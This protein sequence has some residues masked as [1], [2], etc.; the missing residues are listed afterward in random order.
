MLID[1]CG[2]DYSTYGD[3]ARDGPRFAVV[4][5]LLSLEHNWR[6]RVRVFAPDDDFPVVA[7]VGR[8]LA[9]RELVRARGVRSL[10]HRV[11]R[12]IRTCGAF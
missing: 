10:R 2:V 1:V 4:Y 6:L 8:R 7:S 9:R 3:G 5:H 12:D 11:R